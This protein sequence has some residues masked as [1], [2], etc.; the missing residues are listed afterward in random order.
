VDCVD[1][2][3][4]EQL[5][6]KFDATGEQDSGNAFSCLLVGVR[7]RNRIAPGWAAL[8]CENA[9]AKP[10][11]RARALGATPAQITE[12]TERSVVQKIVAQNFRR[13]TQ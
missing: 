1:G 2:R 11:E 13:E 5:T 12:Q 8:P 7:Q 6:A 4:P 10:L 9:I 3:T